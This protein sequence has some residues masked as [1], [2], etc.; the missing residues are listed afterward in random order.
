VAKRGA[1]AAQAHAAGRAMVVGHGT[2]IAERWNF[3]QVVHVGFVQQVQ[4]QNEC[5]LV[6]ELERAIFRSRRP[7]VS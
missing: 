2:D 6:T 4:V 3:V 1:H 5:W 7:S